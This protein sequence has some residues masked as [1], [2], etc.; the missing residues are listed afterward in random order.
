MHQ[1]VKNMDNVKLY[2]AKWAA[3]PR[4]YN[5]FRAFNPHAFLGTMGRSDTDEITKYGQS[6]DAMLMQKFFKRFPQLKVMPRVFG[7][8]REAGTD[9]YK[10]AHPIHD[11]IVKYKKL[12]NKGYSEYK[13]FKIVEEELRDVLEDQ[14]DETR[15][16]RGA[17]MSAYG[18]SYLDRSQRVAELE[19]EMKLMRF[20]RDMPKHERNSDYLQQLEREINPDA[21]DTD[22][23]EQESTRYD[24]LEDLFSKG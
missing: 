20:M 9:H 12:K 17:A 1:I 5:V 19:S 3:K 6:K 18:D 2:E 10:N 7:Y 23:E 8:Y 16:L 24:R 22:A 4:M 13:A 15:I 14:L 21:A 11:F